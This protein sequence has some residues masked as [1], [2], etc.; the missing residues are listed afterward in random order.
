MGFNYTSI[1]TTSCEF[2][3]FG[4]RLFY[5]NNAVNLFGSQSTLIITV[6]LD[7]FATFLSAF[8]L[9]VGIPFVCNNTHFLCVFNY[10]T[11]VL[12]VGNFISYDYI[13]VTISVAGTSVV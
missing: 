8:S 13:R 1:C 10:I 3:L 4:W 2:A 9:Y 11:C 6:Y 5:N 7:D 12:G